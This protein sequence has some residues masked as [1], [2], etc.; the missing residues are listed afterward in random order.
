MTMIQQ[1]HKKRPHYL[2]FAE[3]ISERLSFSF[4]FSKSSEEATEWL[5]AASETA[6][7]LSLVPTIKAIKLIK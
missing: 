6:S 4:S 3:T 2:T 1:L 5:D 7:R